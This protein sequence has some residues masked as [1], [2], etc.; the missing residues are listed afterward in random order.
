MCVNY[1]LEYRILIMS[2]HRNEIRLNCSDGSIGVFVWG[3]MPK[4]MRSSLERN[5]RSALIASGGSSLI[6]T[7]SSDVPNGNNFPAIHFD[8]YA[9]NG[10][11]VH[12]LFQFNS[13]HVLTL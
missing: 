4:D 2:S 9:R 10:T 13:I 1:L 6:N 8:Y 7:D 11:R 12:I 5:I 3:D